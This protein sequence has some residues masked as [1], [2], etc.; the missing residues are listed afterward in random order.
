MHSQYK[1]LPRLKHEYMKK[2][3]L[4]TVILFVISY[5]MVSF[6]YWNLRADLW[7]NDGRFF[8]LLIWVLFLIFS[9]VINFDKK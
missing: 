9:L 2:F 4:S 7:P 6:Y 5:L 8:N 3:Y 1:V